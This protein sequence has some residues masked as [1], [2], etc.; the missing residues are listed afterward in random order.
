MRT[1]QEHIDDLDRMVDSG[2]G[3]HQVR[4]QIAFIAL[5]VAKL[6]ASYAQLAEA[7]TKL[8]G[9]YEAL[10]NRKADLPPPDSFFSGEIKGPVD[11]STD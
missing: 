7:H 4:S 10:K 2:T 8:E 1:L 9:I 5:E 3:V 6:E 11:L